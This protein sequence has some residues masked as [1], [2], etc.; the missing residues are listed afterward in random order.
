M[1]NI[2]FITALSI[3]FIIIFILLCYYVIYCNYAARLQISGIDI[4]EKWD[5]CYCTAEH[6]N[7]CTY[8]KISFPSCF[9]DGL[10]R[11]T[12]NF[13]GYIVVTKY[14]KIP[15][16]WEP[17]LLMLSLGKI[18]DADKTY[19]NGNRIGQTGVFPPHEFS[20]W[21]IDRY[22][23]IKPDIVRY[24]K[25]NTITIVVSCQGYNRI[26][27]SMYI[28]PIDFNDFFIINYTSMI[29]ALMPLYLDIG[30][31]ITFLFIFILLCYSKT[32]RIKYITFILQMIPGVLV[33]AEPSLNIPLYQ[34]TIL[35]LR[36]FAIAWTLLV[37]FHL[38]FLHRIY[39]YKRKYVETVLLM[40]TGILV[41]LIVQAKSIPQIKQAGLTVVFVLTPLAIYNL[42]LHVEQLYKKN[43]FAKLFFPIGVTLAI[44]AAHD[45]IVYLS[46]FTFKIYSLFG[47]EF[48]FPVFQYTSFVIFVGA[49]L[50]IVYQYIS[51]YQEIEN[52]NSILEKRVEERTKEL[53]SS[54]ENL[55]KA[56]EFGVFSIK[57]K[58]SPYFS[59]QLK[60]KITQ[61]IVYINNNY[62]D[63]LSREGMAAMVNIHH[64]YFSKAFKYYTGK[65]VN[66]YI[67]ELRVK[68]AIK[69][70]LESKMNILDIAFNVGFDSVKTF[71]RAFKKI[72]G[73]N[74]TDYRK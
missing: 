26:V 30:I 45:G 71:N 61:A 4:S 48:T 49:G 70:L 40:I 65:S 63:D 16:T 52:M 57:S 59:P 20:Q 22:Y 47:Y 14:I 6:C 12:G 5:V 11:Y 62:R 36:I 1:K 3:F 18:G 7:N 28:V 34:D 42:S 23:L 37:F 27:G 31:G 69:L 41:L 58:T 2:A 72:T 73:K 44:T 56:I 54:L 17:K 9:T 67:Y 55:S 74:P 21:N 33:I 35:R 66:E 24:G 50:I 29:F 68:E 32:D 10:L 25:Q 8:Y 39:N 46:L 38:M 19:F 64:D 43:E 15:D 53:T 60:P 51:M 13:R